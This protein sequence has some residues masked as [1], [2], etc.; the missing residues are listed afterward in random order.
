MGVSLLA[1]VVAGAVFER[2][3][4]YVSGVPGEHLE[5]TRRAI[6]KA[7]RGR[8]FR[9]NTHVIDDLLAGWSDDAFDALERDELGASTRAAIDRIIAGEVS[10]APTAQPIIARST[11]VEDL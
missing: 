7:L 11:W 2:S 1:E 4:T 9:S 5:A 10:E 8:G 6:R 3:S